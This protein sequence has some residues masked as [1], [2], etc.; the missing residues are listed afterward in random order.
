MITVTLNHLCQSPKLIL[1]CTRKTILINDKDTKRVTYIKQSR[2]HWVVGR[3]ICVASHL[4]QLSHTPQQY[5]IRDT[6]TYT[7]MI[8]MHIHTFQS[9]AYIINKE[10]VLLVELY[11]TT[12]ELCANR[13]NDL[14][15]NKQL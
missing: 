3:T 14:I 5:G 13:I 6:R 2:C 15:T 11:L 10:T 8:L 12:T 4:L 7:C 9:R 1:T